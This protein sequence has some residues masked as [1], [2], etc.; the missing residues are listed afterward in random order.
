MERSSQV[1]N[2]TCEAEVW[3]GRSAEILGAS[4][5]PVT[6]IRMIGFSPPHV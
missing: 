3:R 1:N 2:V 5:E 4:G 6:A